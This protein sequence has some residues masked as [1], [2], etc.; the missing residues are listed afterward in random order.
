[1]KRTLLCVLSVL[2]A[3]TLALPASALTWTSDVISNAFD[4]LP[5]EYA[6]ATDVALADFWVEGATNARSGE[7]IG[8]L[9]DFR[10]VYLKA[11]GLGDFTVPF[12]VAEDGVYLFAFR[13]MGWTA[14]VLRSTNVKIDDSSN[15]YIAYDYTEENQ[16]HNHYW[17]GISAE[18][19]AGEH[20]MTLSLADDFDDSNVKS[21]YFADFL[22]VYSTPIPEAA[23]PETEAPAAETEAP[24]AETEAATPAAPQTAD[25]AAASAAAFAAAAVVIIAVSKKRG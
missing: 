23:A 15:V 8:Q 19:T 14:S 16:Y 25:L 1:M 11:D 21:L 7:A 20:T 18:L 2:I 13:I 5:A 3:L 10:Y 4:E 17:Y 24:A 6:N 22:Y 12:T 9:N